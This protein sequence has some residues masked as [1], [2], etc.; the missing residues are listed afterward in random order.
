MALVK[1]M[2]CT[3]IYNWQFFGQ[4]VLFGIDENFVISMTNDWFLGYWQ[5]GTTFNS[6]GNHILVES[7]NHHLL[8]S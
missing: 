4:K 6:Y 7:T 1:T 5:V 2:P 3:G 8:A